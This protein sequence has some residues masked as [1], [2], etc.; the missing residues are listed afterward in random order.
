[1]APDKVPYEEKDL[2]MSLTI[3]AEIL[4]NGAVVQDVEE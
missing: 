4:G 1:M 2:I 3:G